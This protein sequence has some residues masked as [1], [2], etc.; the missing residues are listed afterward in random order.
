MPSPDFEPEACGTKDQ[1][2]NHWPS[3]RHDEERG[4]SSFVSLL[5]M[6]TKK[7]SSSP[8]LPQ[9]LNPPSYFESDRQIKNRP[10][11]SRLMTSSKKWPRSN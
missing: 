6:T 9:P 3:G 7:S 11:C 8:F 2:A 10:N 4:I 5:G 1:T